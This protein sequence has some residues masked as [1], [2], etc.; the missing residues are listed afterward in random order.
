MTGVGNA[1]E[2]E[3]FAAVDALGDRPYYPPMELIEKSL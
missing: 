1:S 3:F 2:A